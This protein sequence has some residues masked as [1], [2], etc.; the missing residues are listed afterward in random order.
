MVLVES[1]AREA[2]RRYYLERTNKL[3]SGSS[4]SAS[5]TGPMETRVAEPDT[6]DYVSSRRLAILPFNQAALFVLEWSRQ[7]ARP[8]QAMAVV[9]SR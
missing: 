3:R 6:S 2:E 8:G 5:S 4:L 7:Q 1:G 9:I